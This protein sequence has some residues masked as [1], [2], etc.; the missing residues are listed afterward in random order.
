MHRVLSGALGA[1]VPKHIPANPA[2]GRRLPRTT[3][4]ITE[5]DDDEV[6]SLTHEEFDALF[7]A[8]IEPYRPMLR[9]MV[10]SGFRLGEVAA[11]KPGDADKEA[12]TEG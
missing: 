7:D 1:A 8:I 12:C 11:L 9:F 10:A 2:A 5:H 6:R 4:E 3:G